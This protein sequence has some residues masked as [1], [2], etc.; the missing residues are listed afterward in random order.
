MT[1]TPQD[2][3]IN[4]TPATVADVWCVFEHMMVM[5]PGQPPEVVF[6]GTCKLIDV[7]RLREARANSYWTTLTSAG[8]PVM[9]RIISTMDDRKTAYE[10]AIRHVRTFDPV[11]VCN[12]HGYNLYGSQ[13][14]ILCSNGQVYNSQSEAAA[15]LN[16][17]QSAISQQLA[18]KLASVKGY[19][20][21]YGGKQ[22]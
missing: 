9:I 22:P 14:Q 3:M 8:A 12:M 13:R 17:T 15:D 6:V 1:I 19:T 4:I 16:I 11:P 10:T 18:G 21:T 5:K 20:F 7:F 2:A